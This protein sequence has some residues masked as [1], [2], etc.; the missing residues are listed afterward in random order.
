[1]KLE[2]QKTAITTPADINRKWYVVDAQGQTLGRLASAIA[3]YLTGKKKPQYAHNL[4]LGDFII[5]INADKIHTTRNRMDTKIY[6]RH[7][8]YPGGLR[9]MTLREMLKKYPERP[10]RYAVRGMLPKGPLGRAMLKKL[11]VYAGNEHPHEAQKP[12][13]LEF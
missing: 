4:D 1:M 5:V 3:P 12:E 10:L 6:Y 7:T 2:S 8:G 13:V 11:K 9:Q